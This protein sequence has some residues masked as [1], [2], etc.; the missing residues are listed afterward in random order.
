MVGEKLTYPSPLSSDAIT[1]PSSRTITPSSFLLS[2]NDVME[3][4]W[5]GYQ[6]IRAVT[7]KFIYRMRFNINADFHRKSSFSDWAR[8][9]M[10]TTEDKVL[11]K[12]Q[13]MNKHWEKF[14]PFNSLEEVADRATKAVYHDMWT[15]AVEQF[16]DVVDFYVSEPRP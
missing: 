9:M 4:L 15:D 6:E 16:P 7:E 11:E 10:D 12:Y 2:I 5:D 13:F 3:S 14:P 1:V 8:G